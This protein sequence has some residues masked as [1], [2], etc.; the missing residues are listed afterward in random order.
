MITP[1]TP[2]TGPGNILLVS[3]NHQQMID[4]AQTIKFKSIEKRYIHMVMEEETSAASLET[5]LYT[6][7][8]RELCR[9]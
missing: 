7:G 8:L 3:N 9:I 6:V 1:F 2:P 4:M 5:Q